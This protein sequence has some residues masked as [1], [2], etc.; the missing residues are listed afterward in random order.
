[1]CQICLQDVYVVGG[2]ISLD[3][4]DTGNVFSIPSNKY[5]EFNMFLDPL[6]ANRVFHS[7]LNITL[8]PLG[9]QRKVSSFPS[10]LRS[11]HLT[12]RTPET[13]FAR[14]LLS[15]L[16]R[17]QR[18]HHRYHHMVNF[19]VLSSIMYSTDLLDSYIIHYDLI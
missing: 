3:Y 1:M 6:A 14:H 5:A 2:H 16:Y 10:V 15:R 9:I 7:A 8:I 12:N 18:T 13:G 17:L 11:L 4:I 19:L